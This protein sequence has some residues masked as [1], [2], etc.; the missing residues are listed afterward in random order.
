MAEEEISEAKLAANGIILIYLLFTIAAILT[1]A[2]GVWLGIL[3]IL[4]MTIFTY[5]IAPAY[6]E[7]FLVFNYVL[8]VLLIVVILLTLASVPGIHVLLMLITIVGPLMV[9]GVPIGHIL[10]LV[11]QES[12]EAAL[13][14]PPTK[15]VT[16]ARKKPKPQKEVKGKI[17]HSFALFCGYETLKAKHA[18]GLLLLRTALTWIIG[19][20]VILLL[21]KGLGII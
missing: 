20:A 13:A 21:S 8:F 2:V 5:G 9:I 7:V 11:R 14:P 16:R 4:V 15:K 1:G 19:S 6:P 10:Y 18:F 3:A 17:S 12:K